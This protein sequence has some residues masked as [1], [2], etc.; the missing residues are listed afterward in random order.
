MRQLLAG[1]PAAADLAE[2]YAWPEGRCVRVNFV[3]S[4]DGA[5]TFE[6]RSA[7]LS[8]SADKEVFHHLRATCDVVLVGAGTARTERYGPAVVPVAVV[9]NRLSLH[10]DDR[11]F[12]GT[13]GTARPIVLLPESADPDR[14]AALEPHADLV[15]VGEDC[16]DLNRAVAALVELGY[17]RILC[18]G[19]PV[20]F[21]DLLAARCVDELC[22]TISPL[23]V[24]G[25][26]PRIA[27]GPALEGGKGLELLSV[28][29]TGSELL[30]RYALA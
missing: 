16:V 25:Q 6:G 14:R 5:A 1:A 22:L 26:A 28:L 7:G 27:H 3:S 10:V 9:T 23:L 8:S 4:A 19:G 21:A 12:A 2:V 15:V 18:E 24:S 30:L 11:L 20:L 13:A 17:R 29:Q